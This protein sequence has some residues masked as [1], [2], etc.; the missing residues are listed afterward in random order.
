[1]PRLI[2][3]L[4]STRAFTTPFIPLHP[5]YSRPYSLMAGSRLILKLRLIRYK[6]DKSVQRSLTI[7]VTLIR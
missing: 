2:A 4:H 6:P 3:A 1:M 7:C 5:H